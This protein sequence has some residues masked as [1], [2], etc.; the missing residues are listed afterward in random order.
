MQ[1]GEN[2]TDLRGYDHF[3]VLVG[4]TGTGKSTLSKFLRRDPSLAIVENEAEDL[5]FVDNEVRIGNED[6]FR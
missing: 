6:S 3:V 4:G 2:A 5:V 1:D